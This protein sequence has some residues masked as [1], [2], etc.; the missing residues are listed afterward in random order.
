MLPAALT[1]V[2]A[3]AQKRLKKNKIFCLSAKHISQT[4]GVDIICFDKVFAA[5]NLPTSWDLG[6]PSALI[7]ISLQTGTLTESEIELEGVIP[8]QESEIRKP[9]SKPNCLPETHPLLMGIA[10]CHSLIRINDQLSG[11]SID[12]KMFHAT[13]W[14]FLIFKKKMFFFVVQQKGTK[15]L[16]RDKSAREWIVLLAWKLSPVVFYR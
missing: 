10:S 16:V 3:F 1:S 15:K 13:Q 4:G 6:G 12:Q 5:S 8:I 2:T 9:V 14:V 11:Y 7:H